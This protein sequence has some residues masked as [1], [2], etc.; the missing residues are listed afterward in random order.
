MH[1]TQL[2]A[3]LA[4]FAL[5]GLLLA[6]FPRRRAAGE[7]MAVL[8]IVYP[9]TRWPLEALRGDEPAIFAG[10]TLSQNIS[11]ALF[12]CGLAMWLGLRRQSVCQRR[13]GTVR[14][15]RRVGLPVSVL[16]AG[17]GPGIGT[18]TGRRSGRIGIKRRPVEEI[19][20]AQVKAAPHDQG[21]AFPGVVARP[22]PRAGVGLAVFVPR[23]VVDR[24]VG[25]EHDVGL[26]DDFL[27]L[28]DV[29]QV[30]E[31]KF[32]GPLGMRAA[33]PE[34]VLGELFVVPRR[35]VA[36][37]ASGRSRSTRRG[38]SA[39]SHWTRIIV[40]SLGSQS[41][42][43]SSPPLNGSFTSSARKLAGS[44]MC[45]ISMAEFFLPSNR[46]MSIRQWALCTWAS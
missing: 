5:L 15:G 38:R 35:A 23:L 2:Y 25:P 18:R 4:G 43:P 6:Y 30:G 13:D 12:A 39:C 41:T 16:R 19:P 1:P 8:M 32:H 37:A 17:V 14:R 45:R 10:M 3:S 27:I 44:S 40:N 24:R 34:V 33:D 21:R 7:V 20:R 26:L 28:D 11:V 9:L 22:E 29:R 42:P 36:Q 46:S 31:D